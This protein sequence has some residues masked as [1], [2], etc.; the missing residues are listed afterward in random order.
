MTNTD[1]NNRPH[2]L[3]KLPSMWVSGRCVL[4]DDHP[5][6][7]GY[8]NGVGELLKD[9]GKYAEAEPYVRDALDRRRRVLGDDDPDTRR[10]IR[11]MADVLR[12][13][14]RGDEAEKR[15][16]ELSGNADGRRVRPSITR[17]PSATPESETAAQGKRGPRRKCWSRKELERR[18]VTLPT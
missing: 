3:K 7:L 18:S 16:S 5:D 11:E 2:T 13:M 15:S 17:A 4:G 9:M 12:R 8:L 14:G 1:E 6:A 10:S